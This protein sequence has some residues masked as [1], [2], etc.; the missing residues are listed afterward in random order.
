MPKGLSPYKKKA[1]LMLLTGIG[2][3]LSTSPKQHYILYKNLAKAWREID[4]EKLRSLVWEFRRKRLVNFLENSDGSVTIILTEAGRK[5]A[6]RYKIDELKISK[7]KWDGKWRIIVFDIPEKKKGSREVLREK[8]KD[9]DFYNIQKS[10]WISPFECKEIIDFIAEYFE[11][12]HYVRYIEA[13]FI[14]NEAELK[15][16]FNLI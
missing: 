9:L 15:L 8:L 1:L 13:G 12:R 14:S 11:I 4:R 3:G 6:L 5:K 7:Q 16:K 2:L 10:V